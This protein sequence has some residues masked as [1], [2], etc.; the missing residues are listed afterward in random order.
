MLKEYVERQ[1]TEVKEREE[2][3]PKKSD[4][5]IEGS[6]VLHVAA[7]AV[8]EQSESGPEGAVDD[9]SLLELG[10]MQPK[11]TVRDVTFG[12]QLNDEQKVQLQEVV[13]Q[14]EH[15]F[16]DV[17]GN[18]NIIEHEVKLTSDEPIRSKPY[19]IPYNVRESLK[20]DV[21]DMIK[22]GVIRESKSPHASPVVIVRKKDGSNRVCVDFRKLNRVTVF[23]PTPMSTAEEIF[24]KMS[25]AKYLTKLDL[26]KGYWQIPVATEDIP[27][28]AFVTHDGSYEFVRMPF[29]MMNS[30]ATLV[31]G[32]R[33][34]L[35]DLDEA[36]SYIDDNRDLKQTGRQRD[37]DGY[38]HNDIPD[39][40]QEKLIIKSPTGVRGVVLGLFTT[41][42][43]RFLRLV[44]CQ[45]ATSE[46]TTLL[47]RSVFNNHKAFVL[48][49]FF[50]L[51]SIHIYMQWIIHNNS[52]SQ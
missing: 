50:K 5:E 13:K 6:S 28:T 41:A 45:D 51:N 11:E 30:G 26:S 19:T 39:L 12:Q 23:D 10:T 1:T 32:I 48:L 24:Q 52:S 21:R 33:K 17:P 49:N 36:D 38:S 22:M 40:V 3:S 27:K 20:K 37:D 31:R 46:T 35:D 7:A 29:G 4:R 18:A 47:S 8:I 14:Y 2:A 16:T 9:E 42:K 44:T 34:L 15:I 25:K 43:Q